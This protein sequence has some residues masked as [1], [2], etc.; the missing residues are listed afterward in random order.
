LLDFELHNTKDYDN[1][2]QVEE[3]VYYEETDLSG[4]IEG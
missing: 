2:Q 1:N 4:G 3:E